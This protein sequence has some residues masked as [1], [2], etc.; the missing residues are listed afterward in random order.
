MPIKDNKHYKCMHT[1]I[2][3]YTRIGLFDIKQ[4]TGI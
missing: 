4:D 2:L 3:D 1:I